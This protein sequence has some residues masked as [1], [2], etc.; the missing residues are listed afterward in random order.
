MVFTEIKHLWN[1]ET[2]QW[3][4]V[5]SFEKKTDKERSRIVCWKTR[6]RTS[7]YQ[8]TAG[9]PWQRQDRLGPGGGQKAWAAVLMLHSRLSVISWLWTNQFMFFVVL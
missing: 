8:G 2:C 4:G 9:W 1:Y 7:T 3:E 6:G 5:F